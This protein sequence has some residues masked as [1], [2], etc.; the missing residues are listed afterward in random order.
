MAQFYGHKRCAK[1]IYRA[2]DA[3]MHGCDYQH[4]TGVCRGCGVGDECTKF[5]KGPRLKKNLTPKIKDP[6]QS[7][8][9]VDLY[10]GDQYVKNVYG[11]NP[12]YSWGK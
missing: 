7:L 2:S 9:E 11:E 5:V 6:D 1:C 3:C 10:R 4:F 12:R 8:R